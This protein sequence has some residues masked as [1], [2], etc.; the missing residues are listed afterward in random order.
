MRYLKWLKVKYTIVEQ[1]EWFLILFIHLILLDNLAEQ[2]HLRGGVY[3]ISSIP[4]TAT[5]KP[6]RRETKE[7]AEKLYKENCEKAQKL[8]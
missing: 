7:I 2:C 3:F 4:L 5:E 6:L 1:F 8:M